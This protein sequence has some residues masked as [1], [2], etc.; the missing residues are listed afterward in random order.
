M[1]KIFLL[2]HNPFILLYFIN[3]FFLFIY[4]KLDGFETLANTYY[5]IFIRAFCY[6][7]VPSGASRSYPRLR[8]GS[9]Q[10]PATCHQ[11]GKIT[12]FTRPL[13]IIHPI[14]ITM[15]I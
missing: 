2:E 1:M 15:A 12:T 5:F 7:A 3:M 14:P 11:L 9:Y 13:C 4:R 8:H 10:A 6:P